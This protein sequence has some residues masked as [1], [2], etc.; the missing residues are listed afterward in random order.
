MVDTEENGGV[1]AG[2]YVK[3]D[4]NETRS[5]GKRKHSLE[6]H[7]DKLDNSVFQAV[8][9]EHVLGRDVCQTRRRSRLRV[10]VVTCA[11]F[12]DS[13]SHPLVDLRVPLAAALAGGIAAAAAGRHSWPRQLLLPELR[14]ISMPATPRCQSASMPSTSLSRVTMT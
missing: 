3:K 7:P 12:Q 2:S 9:K 1:G 10:R 4:W 8:Q 6:R 11:H 5:K 13:H 14:P